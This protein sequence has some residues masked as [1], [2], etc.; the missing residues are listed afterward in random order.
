[1]QPLN[2]VPQGNFEA[3]SFLVTPKKQQ[4]ISTGFTWQIDDKTLLKTEFAFSDYDANTF[5]TKDKAG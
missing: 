4:V 2:G 3:A 1:M 5:S